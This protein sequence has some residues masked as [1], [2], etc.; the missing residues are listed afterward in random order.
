MS[1]IIIEDSLCFVEVL[2]INLN[3]GV[4]NKWKYV[5]TTIYMY[6]LN[7]FHSGCFDY[8]HTSTSSLLPSSD[9]LLI[10]SLEPRS[11]VGATKDLAEFPFI[12][13]NIE[14]LST[15]SYWW[16]SCNTSSPWL[17]LHSTC[18]SSTPNEAL[19]YSYSWIYSLSKKEKKTEK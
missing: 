6:V 11:C 14:P 1:M 13:I 15:E 2:L 8:C 12:Y 19:N 18:T 4:E 17:T 5:K 9:S 7:F 10:L 3:M 16:W